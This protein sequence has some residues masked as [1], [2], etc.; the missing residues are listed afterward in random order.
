MGY[1]AGA[2]IVFFLTYLIVL[3]LFFPVLWFSVNTESS[4]KLVKILWL[5]WA[6][7]PFMAIP[8]ADLWNPETGNQKT[9][10]SNIEKTA[11]KD[12]TARAADLRCPIS[13]SVIY[14]NSHFEDGD[15]IELRIFNTMKLPDE[16]PA[17]NAN[18]INT[19]LE[20]N[21]MCDSFNKGYIVEYKH[22]INHYQSKYYRLCGHLEPGHKAKQPTPKYILEVVST[23][24][25]PD[26]SPNNSHNV[27]T[28]SFKL[29]E[30]RSNDVLAAGK[31]S[32]F[33]GL[34]KLTS[35]CPPLGDNVA[36]LLYRAYSPSE[37]GQKN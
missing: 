2:S 10:A 33:L 36:R 11:R 18:E 7:W 30:K 1:G 34:S 15:E 13:K 19:Y 17:L 31:L 32:I 24:N 35:P 27:V 12:G 22:I 9:L 23:L 29:I 3:T 6:A 5:L 25:H 37:I 8:L 16:T 4:R 20:K 28:T 14:K 21:G 26:I